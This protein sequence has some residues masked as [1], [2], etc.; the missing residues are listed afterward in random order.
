MVLKMS[1]SC[2]TFPISYLYEFIHN[3]YYLLFAFDS[4]YMT[5]V[6]EAKHLSKGGTF[7]KKLSA[8]VVG[9]G[10]R[11]SIYAGY[12]TQHPEDLEIVGVADANPVR[13]ETA[14]ERHNIPSDRIFS[15]W[16]ELTAQPKMADF[17][18]VATQDNM[19]YEPAL[20][21]I[22]KGYNL[23]LEKP[24]APT[25][26]QCK[27]IAEAAERKG[28]R[29]VVCHVLRFTNIWRAIKNMV[30]EDKLGKIVSIAAMENVGHIHQSHSYVRGNWRNTAE[31]SC[32]I[33]AKCCHDM[34]ILQWVLGSKCV[35]VQSFGSL[36]H[37]RPENR[38]AGAPDRCIEGCPHGDT[39]YY[40]AVKLYYDD[41]KNYWFRHACTETIDIPTDEQVLEA[42]KTGPYG[43]CVYACDNDVVDHQVVNLEFDDGCTVS[44]TM[45]AF[46]KGGRGIHIYGT[47]GELFRECGS[48]TLKYF[49]FDTRTWENIEVPPSESGHEGGDMGIMKDLVAL[50][51][52]E[53]PSKSVCEVRTSCE[54]HLIGFA[55]EQARLEGRV[56]SLEDF[57]KNI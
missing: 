37:F 3:I 41:K 25:A 31:S 40:N 52:G 50:L 19:H 23:L 6:R 47:K 21:L 36:T 15:S 9:Y 44:F 10:L 2:C 20:A 12:A 39:C 22:E 26:K 56:V 53:A 14:K 45:N 54:N 35:R 8:V 13:R 24:M 43:R 16:E 29:V 7:M 32:M 57:V 38:P 30:D 1:P 42:L 11:G 33:M 46:N 4:K 55:A 48:K 17:A 28:V 18:I 34:D 51:R 49:S 27:D 5:M